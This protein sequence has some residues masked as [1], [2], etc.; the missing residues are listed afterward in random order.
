MHPVRVHRYH[1]T[2]LQ[3]LHCIIYRTATDPC[4][5]SGHILAYVFDVLMKIYESYGYTTREAVAS[6]VENNL[7]GLDIDDRAAQ[8]AYFAVMMKA[9]QYDRR[10]FS[11]GIQPHVY[12]IAESNRVDKFAVDYFCNGDAKLKEAMD[13]II[14]ELHDA[15]EY[16]AILTVTRQDW[17]ALYDRFAEITEDINMSRETALRELLPLVQVAEVLAQKYDAY[18][19]NPPY[20][21]NKSMSNNIA[22]YLKNNFDGLKMDLFAVFVKKGFEMTT[23]HGVMGFMI[24]FVWMFISSFSELRSTIIENGSITSLIQLEYSGFDGA[25]VPICTYTLAKVSANTMGEYIK[26][27]H[28]RGVDKQPLKTL[29][30]VKNGNCGYRYSVKTSIFKLFPENVIAYWASHNFV[31]LFE[32]CK[33]LDEIYPCKKGMTTGDNNKF[34]RMWYEISNLD[35]GSRY[36]YYCKGGGYRRWYGNGENVIDWIDNGRRLREFKGATLR[37]EAYYFKKA[38]TWGLITSSKFSARAISDEYAIGDAGPICI[39][40]ET[41]Y[42]YI[43]AYLN[44]IV[45]AYIMDFLNPTMNFS[46]G[47]IGSLPYIPFGNIVAKQAIN[48]LVTKNIDIAK[49]E[50]DIFETSWDFKR[51]PLLR[52][53]P[54]IAEAFD[55]W[56]A[57]CDDR[58]NQLKAN[59]EELNRIFIDIYGLQEELTP[60]VEDKD[61]TVRKADPGRDIRSF[62]SYAVGCMFGRYSLDVDGLAYAG[63]EW[64]NNKYVSFSA[65]KNNIIPI[66]DDEYFEDDIVGMFVKFVETVY[67]VDTL[68]E[69][70]KFIAD[71]LGGKGQPKN[72]IRNYF[73]SDFYSD[74]CRVYQK[75]PIYWLFNSGKKNGFKA[76]IYMHRY[77]PDTIARIRTDYVHEQQSRYRTAIA[78]L[79]K[80]MKDASTSERVKLNKQLTKFQAQAEE[81]RIYE[82]KIHHLADQMISIDLDDG[83]KVNYAKFQDVLAKIK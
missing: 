48:N 38:I 28:F 50:W 56:R 68:D 9:R 41:E 18:I 10:F 71:A 82:E 74:H 13:T 64:D 46:S 60:E 65:D 83:V 67:G 1:S 58:F 34:L 16:G 17:P 59:E 37:N 42:A 22:S 44:S 47:V 12:A 70:L 45:A 3:K 21:G 30:A 49:K 75:R 23:K 63:G 33:R 61:V 15:K 66:C 8:L 40:V 62:I 35:I 20:L 26:L 72:V 27:S 19:T 78:D 39:P 2:D 51:H 5:G 6:I 80:R 73:L 77:R 81:T 57:E 69:N 79:E 32:Q 29:E 25:T 11:R 24:P 76:L 7:Y 53:V 4:S 52:K 54:T 31:Y 14:S 36:K 55:Q 43:L